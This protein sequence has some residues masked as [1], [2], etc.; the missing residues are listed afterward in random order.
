MLLKKQEKLEKNKNWKY[1]NIG[2][3]VTPVARCFIL[4]HFV[5]PFVSPL[6]GCI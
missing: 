5:A 4:F 6:N 3:L 2:N 1:R